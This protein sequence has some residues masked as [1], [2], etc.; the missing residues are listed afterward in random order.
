MD[1]TPSSCREAARGGGESARRC[2][3]AVRE[4]GG[5]AGLEPGERDATGDTVTL[6]RCSEVVACSC[7]A[8]VTD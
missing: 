6:A 8:A 2:R 5:A 3:E 7:S 1:S 4:R